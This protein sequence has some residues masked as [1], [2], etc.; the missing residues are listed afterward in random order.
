ML[1]QANVDILG[2][3]GPLTIAGGMA[4]RLLANDMDPSVLRTNDVL[5]FRDWIELDKKVVEVARVNLGAVADLFGRGLTYPISDALGVTRLEWERISD[6][7]TADVNMSGVAEG[8]ND[9]VNFDMNFLPIPIVHKDFNINIRAL[10]S[11]RRNGHPLDLTQ[12][13][14]ATRIV[15]EKIESMLFLGGPNLGTLGGRVYGYTNAPNAKAANLGFNWGLTATTGEQRLSDLLTIWNTMTGSPNNMFGPY[16]IYIPWAWM[17]LLGDDFKANG[18]KSMLSRLKE[19]PGLIDIKA[20]S[21][22]TT[23]LVVV[24]MT[25]DVVDMI[26]GI[27]PMALQWESHGGMILNFKIM[28]IMV[29]RM[30]STYISQSGIG[31][32]TS[33]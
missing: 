28:A 4:A 20:T 13:G 18:D 24:Q 26:D 5:R 21:F 11:S 32:F 6:F 27:Q 17:V 15:S 3:N 31:V 25:D 19:I 23:Q 14:L 22:L 1:E 33:P 29:P 12:A 7:G 8:R 10:H 16:M 30:K 2:G 9:R